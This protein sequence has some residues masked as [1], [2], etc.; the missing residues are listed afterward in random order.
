MR[1]IK[2][3]NSEKY[4]FHVHTSLKSVVFFF[5]AEKFVWDLIQLGSQG[6]NLQLSFKVLLQIEF[7]GLICIL[8]LCLYVLKYDMQS[9]LL[10]SSF[11]EYQM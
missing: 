10:I 2:K 8:N 4:K 7:S 5:C 3:Y 11:F 6:S 1:F 9:A